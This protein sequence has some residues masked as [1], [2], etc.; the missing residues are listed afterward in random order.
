MGSIILASD[1]GWI[2]SA[3]IESL[4]CIR[5]LCSHRSHTQTVTCLDINTTGCV[6]SGGRDG[7]VA[8]AQG[9]FGGDDAGIS[10]CKG[11]SSGA[12]VAVKFCRAD[13]S[14]LASCS[15][16]ASVSVWGLAA[17]G[18][19]G[20][21]LPLKMFTACVGRLTCLE[22][23]SE[24]ADALIVGGE[25]QAVI[26]VAWRLQ[27]AAAAKSTSGV[28]NLGNGAPAASVPKAKRQRKDGC[29]TQDSA[30]NTT[31]SQNVSDEKSNS[32]TDSSEIILASAGASTAFS[33]GLNSKQLASVTLRA[34]DQ[35]KGSPASAKSDASRRKTSEKSVLIRGSA[36]TVITRT[37]PEGVESLMRM[38]GVASGGS[39]ANESISSPS[40][41]EI[42]CD[43]DLRAAWAGE[44]ALA[45][46][47]NPSTADAAVAVSALAG[48]YLH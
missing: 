22:W 5:V 47:K 37:I 9:L 43:T 19:S 31:E 18:T 3:S 8:V 14:L 33:D 4:G 25:Q 15:L 48:V 46:A 26:E 32:V 2:Y 44:C 41:A 6:A 16:E 10:C 30:G 11:S 36:A 28:S 27:P 29:L 20:S 1:N 45:A 13:A 7:T 40:F 17:L 23:V 35:V 21:L 38:R 24:S 39:L 12:V 34:V 42:L